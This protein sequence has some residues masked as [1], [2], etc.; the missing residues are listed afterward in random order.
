MN[1]LCGVELPGAVNFSTK[2]DA[3]LWYAPPER[4]FRMLA[5]FR[6]DFRMR[7]CPLCVVAAVG[8]V[9]AAPIAFLRPSGPTVAPVAF[10][11]PGENQGGQPDRPDERRGPGQDG[12]GG[13]GGERRVSVEGSMKAIQRSLEALER[14]I[15]DGSKRDENLKLINDAQRGC[16]QAKGAGVPRDILEKAAPDA[17]AKARLADDYRVHLVTTLRKLIDLEEAVAA[18]KAEEAKAALT[19][20]EKIRDDGHNAMGMHE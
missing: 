8:L 7:V 17:A 10:Q 19:A 9:A 1:G 15:G 3:L 20:L 2:L 11:Q 16:I 12:R 5:R 6:G 13:Q 18:G 4:R 14:Q